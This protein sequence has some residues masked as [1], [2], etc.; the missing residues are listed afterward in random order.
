MLN[1]KQI[2][3]KKGNFTN[4]GGDPPKFTVTTFSIIRGVPLNLMEQFQ[5]N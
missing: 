4:I 3:M 5:Y 2:S 1:L